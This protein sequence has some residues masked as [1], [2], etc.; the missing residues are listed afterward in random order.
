M[1]T[2]LL[3]LDNLNDNKAHKS[4]VWAKNVLLDLGF[5]N[6]RNEGGAGLH[7]VQY[8]LPSSGTVFKSQP[9]CGVC[10]INDDKDK[11]I[12]FAGTDKDDKS[13][14]ILVEEDKVT[15]VVISD[16]SVNGYNLFK[17]DP[18]RPVESVYTYNSKGELIIIFSNGLDDN[19]ESPFILNVDN[20]DLRLNNDNYTFSGYEEY[21]RIR[22]KL[23]TP[24]RH[25][26][27]HLTP[28]IEEIGID[29]ETIKLESG[30]SLEPGTVQ[31]AFKFISSGHK[32][33][34][35][36]LP[37]NPIII[38]NFNA[39]GIEEDEIGGIS[40]NIEN[41][42]NKK[43]K[44]GIIHDPYYYYDKFEAIAI[45][46]INGVISVRR[47][48]V[49]NKLVGTGYQSYEYTGDYETEIP[50]DEFLSEYLSFHRAKNITW[51][52]NNLIISNVKDYEEINYQPYACDIKVEW[53]T[54]PESNPSLGMPV[55]NTEVGKN[56]VYN[57]YYRGLEADEV[58][59]LYIHFIMK[60][61][62]K[63]TRGF[64]IPGKELGNYTDPSSGMTVLE[65]S[66]LSAIANAH[67]EQLLTN[68]SNK[69]VSDK[70][71]VFHTRNS[72]TYTGYID[73]GAMGTDRYH[74]GD[75]GYWE[76]HNETY[77]DD[78]R[79]LSPSGLDLR[80][81]KVRHHRTPSVQ[82][83]CDYNQNTKVA[84]EPGNTWKPIGLRISNIVIPPE[85]AD[86]VSGFFISY[87]KR[88]NNNKLVSFTAPVI[89]WDC[90]TLG[91]SRTNLDYI[92]VYEQY[93]L[94]K[95][96][97]SLQPNVEVDIIKCMYHN[98]ATTSAYQFHVYAQAY[99]TAA[100]NFC[101]D[102]TI[103]SVENNSEQY[104]PEHNSQTIPSN[105][106]REAVLV[107]KTDSSLAP[108]ATILNDD[109]NQYRTY[110]AQYRT[111][112]LNLFRDFT[113]QELVF[114]GRIIEVN[115]AGTYTIGDLAGGDRR[116]NTYMPLFGFDT[117]CL[118]QSLKFYLHD[119][120][121]PVMRWG[122]Y[123]DVRSHILQNL[124]SRQLDTPSWASS[125]RVIYTSYDMYSKINDIYPLI[126]FDYNDNLE[127]KFPYNV[128]KSNTYNIEDKSYLGFRLFKA[129][130]YITLE[131][132]K[133]EINQCRSLDKVLLVHQSHSL[134]KIQLVEKL[135]ADISEIYVGSGDILNAPPEDVYPDEKGYL[136]NNSK[137][138]SFT[139]PGGYFFVDRHNGLVGIYSGQIDIISNRGVSNWIRENI[140]TIEDIDRP[141]DIFGLTACYDDKFKR[142]ILSKRDGELIITD[143]TA[144][145]S[146]H[147]YDFNNTTE[148]VFRVYDN[149]A[150]NTVI[151]KNSDDST[152]L[153][154]TSNGYWLFNYSGSSVQ[155]TLNGNA[156]AKI[157]KV[158][159]KTISYSL[160]AKKWISFHD[161]NPN[162][163]FNTRH[164]FFGIKNNNLYL[165]SSPN[166]IFKHNIDTRAGIYYDSTIVKYPSYIDIIFNNPNYE[167]KILDDI[168]WLADVIYDNII[169]YD[170]TITHIMVYNDTQCTGLVEV[171]NKTDWYDDTTGRYV[172]GVWYFDKLNDIVIN[173]KQ[174]FLDDNKEIITAN[175]DKTLKD[176]FDNSDFISTYFVVRLYY[177]NENRKI[178]RF[179]DV[180]IN[181]RKHYR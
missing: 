130:N 38:A 90:F 46:N 131:P 56:E 37:S 159:N 127:T 151:L 80:N 104:Y 82:V 113:N 164:N 121:T 72:A 180:N 108:A 12:V 103:L 161:Y 5:K 26:T 52:K 132:N 112:K 94:S 100:N 68:T 145:N 124:M 88:T 20:I 57:Y 115:G 18:S 117:Y 133:G 143:E 111:V 149:N 158:Y 171:N 84:G 87:A 156:K 174:A 150:G 148:Y 23:F 41:K 135:Q 177:S 67:E 21:N 59:A 137:Y 128:Y 165:T 77:P 4:W 169:H 8:I 139:F 89:A 51:N 29:F 34:M 47:I 160:I 155:I 55:V 81:Q 119:K 11:Y 168:R 176:W 42:V 86:K 64:H 61:D 163:L 36:S 147:N 31:L 73:G 107:V 152:M 136:G 99:G 122:R 166:A 30:G 45:H 93:I 162:F 154:V 179:N 43:I 172:D 140:N 102:D 7:Y 75:M 74:Y 109:T 110:N 170:E 58:Y 106:K 129:N 126:P 3:E 16:S 114:T 66:D 105:N 120:V 13:E 27:V 76:N 48:G 62:G 65:N 138:A 97:Y 83:I 146:V 181:L 19:S 2:N 173:D 9:I 85:I 141:F 178:I 123:G 157:Y 116:S 1:N 53:M 63:I 14:I 79:F 134:F 54:A 22:S 17:F 71:K 50:I 69:F 92:R 28:G 49:Y 35:Y 40:S 78:E 10:P 15:V 91:G 153:N 33:S 96:N 60:E 44:F 167:K 70:L 95:L 101:D 175:V 32:T 98:G 142:I 25:K 144:G 118:P 125:E 24:I 6:S 39:E